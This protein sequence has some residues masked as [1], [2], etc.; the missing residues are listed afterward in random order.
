MKRD[1]VC[2]ILPFS[3]GTDGERKQYSREFKQEAVRLLKTS[4]KSAS[5]LEGELGIG[6]G[7]LSRWKQEHAADGE[8]AFPGHGRLTPEQEPI[9]KPSSLN[10]CPRKRGKVIQQLLDHSDSLAHLP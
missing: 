8:D 3:E 5:E 2:G 10:P 4:G 9:H 7:N 1:L 6:S